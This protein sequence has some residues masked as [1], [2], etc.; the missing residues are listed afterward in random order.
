[1]PNRQ[2][3]AEQR[4]LRTLLR[5][6]SLVL[7]L[8][9]VLPVAASAE[10]PTPQTANEPTLVQIGI[11]LDQIVNIDQ[12]AESFTAA[13]TLQLRYRDPALAFERAPDDRR[14]RC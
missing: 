3:L 9:L 4:S 14:S 10:T 2:S 1:M 12:K 7:T 13:Y 11:K 6:Y 8:L 5:F